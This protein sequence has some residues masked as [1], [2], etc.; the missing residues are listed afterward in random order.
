MIDNN[1]LPIG[2]TMEL[3]QHSNILNRFS[4]LSDAQR[5][6]IIEG[7]RTIESRQEMRNYVQSMFQESKSS[8]F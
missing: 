4:N 2:F 7:A 5:N 6:S 1:E 3:A 8:F